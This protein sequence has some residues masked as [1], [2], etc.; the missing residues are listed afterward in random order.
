MSA[1][2]IVVAVVRRV[3]AAAAVLRVWY[4]LVS[5]V[6][7]GG[8]FV[9]PSPRFLLC[10]YFLFWEGDWVTAPGVVLCYAGAVW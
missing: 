10:L 4:G 1:F 3:A 2:G 5:G 6:C 7:R 8:L 9:E